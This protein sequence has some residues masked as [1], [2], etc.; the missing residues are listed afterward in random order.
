MPSE[1]RQNWHY[2]LSS[3]LLSPGPF[4]I[5]DNYGPDGAVGAWALPPAIAG[6]AGTSRDYGPDGAADGLSQ[7]T[8]GR[9]R[10][11]HDHSTYQERADASVQC[12]GLGARLLAMSD[13]ARAGYIARLLAFLF[14]RRRSAASQRIAD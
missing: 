1:G 2:D 8:P 11:Q 10:G 6:A 3:P 7:R 13:E 5:S 4:T 9:A 12:T 14:F